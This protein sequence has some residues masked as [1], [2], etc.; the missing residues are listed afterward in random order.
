VR[1]YASAGGAIRSARFGADGRPGA[2][3]LVTRARHVFR[4]LAAQAGGRPVA[5]WTFQ[6]PF[7]TTGWRAR[8]ARPAR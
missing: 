1:V 7:S 5:A 8:I 3:S 2:W 4:I 6:P